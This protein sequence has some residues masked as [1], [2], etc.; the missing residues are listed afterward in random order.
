MR[1]SSSALRGWLKKIIDSPIRPE[2]LHDVHGAGFPDYLTHADALYTTSRDSALL[3]AKVPEVRLVTNESSTASLRAQY[4]GH[5]LFYSRQTPAS[6]IPDHVFRTALA[7]RLRTIPKSAGIFPKTCRCGATCHNAEEVIDHT[8]LCDQMTHYTHTCRHN[9][10]RDA[11]AQ[12]VRSY[13]I[14]VTSEPKFYS[15]F[16]DGPAEQRP[17]LTFHTMPKISTD[18][19]IVASSETVGEAANKAAARKIATH[20]EATAQLGHIFMPFALEV[21]GHLDKCCYD[22]MKAIRNY[23][24]DHLHRDFTFDFLHSISTS[25]ASAR[26][27]AVLIAMSRRS[28]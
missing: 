18:L 28:S 24:P 22:L 20:A 12:V 2:L 13:G 8:L 4:N 23:V 26:A 3:N 15:G 27:I 7:I 21:H 5:Y 1:S 6:I 9:D 19:T 17:D 25:L 11:I 10:V 16:Y 14:S